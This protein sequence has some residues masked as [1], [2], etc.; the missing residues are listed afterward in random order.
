MKA[1]WSFIIPADGEMYVNEIFMSIQGESSYAG[2]PC[3]FIRLAGCDLECDWCDTSYARTPEGARE[4]SVDEIISAVSDYDCSMAEITGG[5]PLLQ[6]DTK[7]LLERL[8]ALGKK[9]LLETNGAVSLKGVPPEVIKV[10][11]VKCPSSGHAG[12]FMVDNLDYMDDRDEVKFV[13]AD[14]KDYDYARDFYNEH[15]RG[16]N[17]K[18]LFAPVTGTLHPDVL[19]G[20]ILDDHLQVRLQVQMHRYIWKEVRGR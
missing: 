1:G 3:V 9:T 11:D 12:S 18:V 20:W 16:H 13:I 8:L 5:E 6:E 2:F 10:V 15:L 17:S 4:M 7:E 19:A 14:R